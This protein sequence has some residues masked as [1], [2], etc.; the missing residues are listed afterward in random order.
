VRS[1]G[2]R[3]LADDIEAGDR[4]VFAPAVLSVPRDRASQLHDEADA[5]FGWKN[6]STSQVI[7]DR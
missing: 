3:N 2:G 4:S 1:T 6:A 7:R 5:S